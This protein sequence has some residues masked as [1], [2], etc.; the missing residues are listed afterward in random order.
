MPWTDKS[1]SRSSGSRRL[2][3]ALQRTAIPGLKKSHERLQFFRFLPEVARR[4]HQRS[5][6]RSSHPQHRRRSEQ[7]RRAQDWRWR[8]RHSPMQCFGSGSPPRSLQMASRPATSALGPAPQTSLHSSAIVRRK[9]EPAG[10]QRAAPR[11]TSLLLPL[12]RP[13]SVLSCRLRRSLRPFLRKIAVAVRL[14]KTRS[15]RCDQFACTKGQVTSYC[16][17][18][19]DRPKWG[20]SHSPLSATLILPGVCM[21]RGVLIRCRPGLA[22]Y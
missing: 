5:E 2:K 1:F 11:G 10:P 15:C 17:F 9:G 21:P 12:S 16:P 19:Y 7:P 22:K 14:V 18:Q 13:G 3:H 8:V 4:P 20:N 6:P